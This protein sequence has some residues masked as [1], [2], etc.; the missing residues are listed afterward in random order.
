MPSLFWNRFNKVL[1]TSSEILVH[2][3]LI[4]S[5]SYCR[6]V[7]CTS[8]MLT[9]CS[10]TSQKCSTGFRSGSYGGYLSTGNLLSCSRNQFE[11][12]WGFWHGKVSRWKQHS[13]D[14]YTLIRKEP[15]VCQKISPVPLHHLQSES[16]IKGRM[17]HHTSWMSE[18]KLRLIRPGNTFPMSH[19]G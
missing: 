8:V 4:I 17:S 10:T 13:E 12:V 5:E 11:I 1:E 15:K 6:F 14:G 19:F 16:M 18:Q 2:I 3:R 7:G 9:S